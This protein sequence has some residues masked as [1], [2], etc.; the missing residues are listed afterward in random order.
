MLQ[1]RPSSQVLQYY[2]EAVIHPTKIQC[3]YVVTR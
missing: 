1:V 2:D 3:L